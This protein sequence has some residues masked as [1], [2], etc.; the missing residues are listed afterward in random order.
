MGGGSFFGC[1]SRGGSR[2][3]KTDEN[4]VPPYLAAFWAP[5]KAPR[6]I[7]GLL[8]GLALGEMGGFRELAK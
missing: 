7:E 8:G 3:Q 4:G 5:P 2:L 6:K 1:A